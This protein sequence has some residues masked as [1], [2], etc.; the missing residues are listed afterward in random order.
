MIRTITDVR[1]GQQ[2]LQPRERRRVV[3]TKV[4]AASRSRS[5]EEV[6]LHDHVAFAKSVGQL[7]AYHGPVSPGHLVLAPAV[8]APARHLVVERPVT[9]V[10]RRRPTPRVLRWGKGE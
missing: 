1:V 2:V 6:S 10:S 7:V 3:A 4:E 9:L 8:D 5:P